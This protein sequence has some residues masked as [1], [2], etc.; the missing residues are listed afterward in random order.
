M[1]PVLYLWLPNRNRSI[2]RVLSSGYNDKLVRADQL[3]IGKNGQIVHNE[4]IHTLKHLDTDSPALYLCTRCC[5]WWF[6]ELQLARILL[7]LPST[8]NMRHNGLQVPEQTLTYPEWLAENEIRVREV[9]EI[10]DPS[11]LLLPETPDCVW[12]LARHADDYGRM[13]NPEIGLACIQWPMDQ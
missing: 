9:Q 3:R 1:S 5:S 13:D 2:Q 10:E 11:P 7:L 6:I 4:S 12:Q 8:S